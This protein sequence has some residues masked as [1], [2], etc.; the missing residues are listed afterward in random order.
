MDSSAG[1]IPV[2]HLSPPSVIPLP[3]PHVYLFHS[4]GL[5]LSPAITSILSSALLPIHTPARCFRNCCF[6]HPCP[7]LGFY[8]IPSIILFCGN[9]RLE[10]AHSFLLIPSFLCRYLFYPSS[11]SHRQLLGHR[12]NF[13]FHACGSLHLG[14]ANFFLVLSLWRSQTDR[15]LLPLFTIG[16]ALVSRPP[17]RNM[18]YN[19]A[20]YLVVLSRFLCQSTSPVIRH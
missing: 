5:S 8:R 15:V 3:S 11:R 14:L 19:S 9:G 13:Y 17:G 6:L 18:A 7:S 12:F 10:F 16:T 2:Q 1:R 20:C 4:H